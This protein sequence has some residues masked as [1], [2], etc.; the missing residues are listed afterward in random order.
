MVPVVT[1]GVPVHE[2]SAQEGWELLER[3]AND[4][5]G[6]KAEEFIA[7]WDAGEYRTTDDPRVVRVAM[8][9][10]FVR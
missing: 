9:L 3:M 2:A 10:P 7:A 1:R 6:M 5:L 4:L 8:L